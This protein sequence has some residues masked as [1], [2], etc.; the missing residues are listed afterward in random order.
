MPSLTLREYEE[1]RVNVVLDDTQLAA[2]E[3][4]R[5]SATPDGSSGAAWILKPSSYVGSIHVGSLSVVIRPKIP[6]EPG[7]VPRGVRLRP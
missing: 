3:E 6:V 2:L 4:A 1:R 7:D 5:V